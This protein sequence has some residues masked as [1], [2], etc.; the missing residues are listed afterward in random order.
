[1]AEIKDV[2]EALYD[3]DDYIDTR[4][5]RDLLN[6]SVT[7]PTLI[8]WCRDYHIG[9]KIGGRWYVDPKKLSLLL[10]G[11]EIKYDR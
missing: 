1:M 2:E 11:I 10:R 7:L 5:A 3:I 9:K 6:D 8:K 4:D